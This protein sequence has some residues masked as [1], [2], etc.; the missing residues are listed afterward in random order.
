MPP[1]PE[2]CP[3][4]AMGLRNS[5]L[6]VFF[7]I[8]CSNQSINTPQL[9]SRVGLYRVVGPTRQEVKAER[10]VVGLDTELIDAQLFNCL[11]YT[12]PS[13]RD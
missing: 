4:V 6:S 9:H 1:D 13:P 5:S 8:T 11:L 7:G 10:Y 2:G 3:L 12:S